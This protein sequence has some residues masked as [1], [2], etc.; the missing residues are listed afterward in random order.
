MQIEHQLVKF[1]HELHVKIEA[2]LKDRQYKSFERRIYCNIPMLTALLMDLN[3]EQCR[4][5]DEQ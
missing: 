5:G 2:I 1:Q 4:K 3:H